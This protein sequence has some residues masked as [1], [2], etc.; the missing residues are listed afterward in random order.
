LLAQTAGEYQEK[1][2]GRGLE[3]ILTQP[4]TP[5]RIMADGRHQWRIFDN[6]MSNVCKYSQPSTEFYLFT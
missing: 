4:E 1:L 6:L 2:S 3:L 5:V